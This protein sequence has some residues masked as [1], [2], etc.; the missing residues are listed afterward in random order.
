M[1]EHEIQSNSQS[2]RNRLDK[3]STYDTI[4][5]QQVSDQNQFDRDGDENE[6]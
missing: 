6:G 5:K 2:Q 1:S 3:Y 4:N